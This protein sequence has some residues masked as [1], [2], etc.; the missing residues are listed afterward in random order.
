[1]ILKLNSSKGSQ[2]DAAEETEKQLE[3]L[4]VRPALFPSLWDINFIYQG[5]DHESIA[6][7]MLLRR[8]KKDKHIQGNVSAR[9]TLEPQI[10]QGKLSDQSEQHNTMKSTVESRLCS[11]K[12]LANQITEQVTS[13]RSLVLPA[14]PVEES[15]VQPTEKI[16]SEEDKE[17]DGWES[18]SISDNVE[19]DSD[20]DNS[21]NVGSPKMELVDT[22]TSDSEED[23]DSSTSEALGSS[24]IPL[25][26]QSKKSPSPMEEDEDGAHSSFLPSLAVGYTRGDSD[27]EDVDSMAEESL[28]PR[29]NRRGQR[30]RQA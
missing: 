13:L 4:K 16:G 2:G 15:P 14:K 11:S 10:T 29:K 1:M 7:L 6:T 28:A 17:Q 30:A 5:L 25:V 8:L 18:G 3:V 9:T 24:R 21:G 20:E 19:S 12:I 23:G 27:G 22:A 26:K